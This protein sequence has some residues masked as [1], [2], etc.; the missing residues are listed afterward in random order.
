MGDKI[1][2]KVSKLLK[3]AFRSIDYVCRIG[4]DE[5]AII[6]V[7]MTIIFSPPSVTR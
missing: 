5:F 6:M 2:K 4:G 3:D 1:L 7:E